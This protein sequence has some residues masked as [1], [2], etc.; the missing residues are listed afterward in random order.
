[1]VVVLELF[2]NEFPFT[3]TGTIDLSS[4]VHSGWWKPLEFS[5][6]VDAVEYD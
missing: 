3:S 5:G 4:L 1:M 6:D 2:T